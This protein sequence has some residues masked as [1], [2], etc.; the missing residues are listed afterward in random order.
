MDTTIQELLEKV[1]AVNC[2]ILWV[3]PIVSKYLTEDIYLLVYEDRNPNFQKNILTTTTILTQ[4]DGYVEIE[5]FLG[6]VGAFDLGRTEKR[7]MKQLRNV[8]T[9]HN[10]KIVLR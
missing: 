4:K 6:G 1:Y 8:L 10:I 9:K 3:E 2:T 5:H 7:L